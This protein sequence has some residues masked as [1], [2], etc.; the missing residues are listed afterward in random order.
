MR[1]RDLYPLVV[2][3]LRDFLKNRY[4]RA[5]EIWAEETS[6]SSVAKFLSKHNLLNL[7]RWGAMLDISP[8]VTGAAVIKAKMQHSVKL[9]IVEVKL[10]VVSLRDLS[11]VLG[12]AKVTIPSHAFI[13]SPKGWSPTI[14]RLVR[15]FKRLDILEYAQGKF[16]VVAKWDHLSNSVRPG[17]V[18]LPGIL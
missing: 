6:R 16:I 3:W 11:Q 9:A 1:E 10:G 17:D 14:Q 2:E 12:Y 13:I 15:D 5:I 18:L 8:D 7:V 4:P